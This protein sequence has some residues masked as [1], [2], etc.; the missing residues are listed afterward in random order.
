MLC[1]MY[2]TCKYMLAFMHACT[3]VILHMHALLCFTLYYSMPTEQTNSHKQVTDMCDKAVPVPRH[4]ALKSYRELQ[5]ELYNFE[6]LYK[7]IQRT[8]TVQVQVT[9]RPTVSRSVYL[10]V[11]HPFRTRDQ[12]PFLSW[13]ILDG[14]WFNDVGCF[15]WREVGFLTLIM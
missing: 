2:R 1:A 15:L 8:Y 10:G 7:S 12:F 3:Y 6:S 14:F 4:Y 11:R 13:I 5:K 9:L